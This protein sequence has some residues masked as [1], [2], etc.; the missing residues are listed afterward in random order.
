MLQI[1][2]HITPNDP[3]GLYSEQHENN[4]LPNNTNMLLC[5]RLKHYDDPILIEQHRMYD[6]FIETGTTRPSKIISERQKKN[7]INE[8]YSNI[9]IYNKES[10]RSKRRNMRLYRRNE[11]L[12]DVSMLSLVETKKLKFGKSAIHKWGVFADEIIPKNSFVIEYKGQIISGEE[13]DR[14]E[15]LY[16]ELYVGSDYVYYYYYYL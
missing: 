16:K 15:K 7:N 14:R 4:T 9:I 3:N 10:D 13:A 8:E 1:C 2:N 6:Y 5:S 11:D 12:L